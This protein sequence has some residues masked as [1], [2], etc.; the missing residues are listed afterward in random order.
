MPLRCDMQ[1]RPMD[2]HRPVIARVINHQHISILADIMTHTGAVTPVNRYGITKLDTD[3]LSRVSFEKSVDQLVQAA[4]F[5]EEDTV[6]SVSSR[7]I[8]GRV[9]GGGTGSM[10]LVLDTQAI[11]ETERAPNPLVSDVTTRTIVRLSGNPIL[12]DALRR[13][14]SASEEGA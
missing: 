3:P 5:R 1:A 13:I 10:E 11:M 4:V 2:I 7:I 9:M 8:T 6:T 12:M 14:R